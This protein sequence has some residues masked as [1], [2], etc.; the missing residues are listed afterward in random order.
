MTD[1]RPFTR[2][3]D[4]YILRAIGEGRSYKQMAQILGRSPASI[5]GRLRNIRAE[6][7]RSELRRCY[8]GAASGLDL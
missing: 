2:D 7:S 6:T 1:R 4:L 5:E 3:D 8:K